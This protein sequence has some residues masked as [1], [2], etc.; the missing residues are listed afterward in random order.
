MIWVGHIAFAACIAAIM[1]FW[2]RTDDGRSA[3]YALLVLGAVSTALVLEM[4]DILIWEA[5][6]RVL[7]EFY[8]VGGAAVILVL[9]WATVTTFIRQRR[10][11]R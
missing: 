3:L 9:G 10:R 2:A 1:M 5:L 6:N 11:T 4:E 7:V 8:E